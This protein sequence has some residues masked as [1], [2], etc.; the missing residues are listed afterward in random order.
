[1][2]LYLTWYYNARKHRELYRERYMTMVQTP[3]LQMEANGTRYM[4]MPPH[5]ANTV[6]RSV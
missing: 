3:K 4:P 5:D 6:L 2:S 1:M